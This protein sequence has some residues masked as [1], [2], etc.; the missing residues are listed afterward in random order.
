ML[1]RKWFFSLHLKLGSD[2]FIGVSNLEMILFP[3]SQVWK[4][5]ISWHFK[6]VNDSFSGVSSLEMI[7]FP[8]S[9][10]CKWF[11]SWCL[12]CGN[13]S[14]SQYLKPGNDFFSQYL[15][16][17]NDFFPGVSSLEIILFPMSQVW[18][19]FFSWHLK[20][21]NDSFLKNY[22]DLWSLL[23]MINKRITS[24]FDGHCQEWDM[25]VIVFR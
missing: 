17:G 10:T 1:T 22:S 13:D 20:S 9:Q 18:K 11:F 5:F 3:M 16:P 15:K 12:K 21:G 6:P 25:S 7:L 8:L 23:M 19:W 24:F 4:W 14:F 2:S